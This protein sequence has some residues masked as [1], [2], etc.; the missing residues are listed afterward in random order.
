M[1]HITES[2]DTDTLASKEL[3]WNRASRSP[4]K[5]ICVLYAVVTTQEGPLPID[6]LVVGK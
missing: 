6:E 4:A 1:K 5:I 3:S 2:I